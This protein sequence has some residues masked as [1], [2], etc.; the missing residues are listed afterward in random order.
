MLCI[1]CKN[2]PITFRMTHVHT[3]YLL[4]AEINLRRYLKYVQVLLFAIVDI[5]SNALRV[6]T[7]RVAPYV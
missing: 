6:Y 7:L 2:S 1:F 5:S 3:V 4:F